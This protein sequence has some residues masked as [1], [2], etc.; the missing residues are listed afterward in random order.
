MENLIR[1]IREEICF[2]EHVDNDKVEAV[3]RGAQ[4]DAR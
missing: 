4:I 2:S 1:S 3:M